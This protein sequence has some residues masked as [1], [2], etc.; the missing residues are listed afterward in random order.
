MIEDQPAITHS[1]WKLPRVRIGAIVAVALAAGFVTWL[2][3]RSDS[4]GKSLPQTAAPPAQRVVPEV[5]SPIRLRA[6]ASTLGYP[7]YWAGPRVGVRYELTRTT[8]GNVYIRY[9]PPDAGAGDR[10]PLFLAIGSYPVRNPF[11]QI[12]AASK[13]PGAVSLNL[14]GGGIAVYDR[15]RPT[16]VY[17]A[18]PDSKVQVEV[19]APAGRTARSLVLAG[20]VAPI[21]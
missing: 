18:Y 1:G 12:K 10:R 11:A 17:F 19:Y 6:L 4:G 15:S 21:R 9:L 8:G 13:R 3:L 16:S 5:V 14:T 20:R 7:L 2:A